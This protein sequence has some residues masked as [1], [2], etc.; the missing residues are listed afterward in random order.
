MARTLM[1]L[2]RA[3]RWLLTKHCGACRQRYSRKLPYCP[4]CRNRPG[5]IWDELDEQGR[6]ALAMA[7]IGGPHR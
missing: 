2:S 5:F 3:K 7:N 1:H 4:V 6:L